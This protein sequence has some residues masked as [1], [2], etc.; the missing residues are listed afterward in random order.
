MGQEALQASH[1]VPGVLVEGL[2]LVLL[3]ADLV[4]VQVAVRL[5]PVPELLDL[6]VYLL[7]VPALVVGRVE[8]VVELRSQV[9]D[10]VAQALR[11]MALRDHH[12]PRTFLNR[13]D[14]D[15]C[16][17]ENRRRGIQAR[18]VEATVEL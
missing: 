10:L 7:G 6:L 9:D 4:A 13:R 8:L 16:Q 1:P 14:Q 2:L 11:D 5:D 12:P 18:V 15:R 17:V 3:V